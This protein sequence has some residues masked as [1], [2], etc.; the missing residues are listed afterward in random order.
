MNMFP[1]LNKPDFGSERGGENKEKIIKP[2]ELRE[3][4]EISVEDESSI[5]TGYYQ[6]PSETYYGEEASKK[7]CFMV[8]IEKEKPVHP[9]ESNRPKSYGDGG[10]PPILITDSELKKPGLIIKLKSRKS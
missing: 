7:P 6:R 8:Y 9:Y 2:S 3:G 4:D 5:K 1:F 10:T